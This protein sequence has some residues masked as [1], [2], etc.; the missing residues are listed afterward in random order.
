MASEE[1]ATWLK[2]EDVQ[3]GFIDHY[4]T[5]VR[6]RNQGYNVIMEYVPISFDPN[7]RHTQAAIEVVNELGIGGAIPES[8]TSSWPKDGH[9]LYHAQNCETGQQGTQRGPNY[10]GEESFWAK[11]YPGSEKMP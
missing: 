1:A 9:R 2:C 8:P 5:P 4:G 11:G 3:K 6:V 10:R 7:S